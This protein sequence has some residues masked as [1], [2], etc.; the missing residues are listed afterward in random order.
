MAKGVCVC[1]CVCTCVCVCTLVCACVCGVLYHIFICYVCICMYVCT[2]VCVCVCVCVCENSLRFLACFSNPAI[3]DVQRRFIVTFYLAD[4]TH[5]H[6][7]TYIQIHT[8]HTYTTH[9]PSPFP[10]IYRL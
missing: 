4:N 6:V 7:H 5:T 1:L 8:P 10:G 2:C 9:E 3:E